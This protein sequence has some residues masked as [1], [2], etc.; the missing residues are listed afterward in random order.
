MKNSFLYTVIFSFILCFLSVLIL[1]FLNAATLDKVNQYREFIRQQAILQALGAKNILTPEDAQAQYGNVK[2][3]K[4]GD[5]TYYFADF[6]G[7]PAVVSNFTGPG[8]WG[9]ISGY[10]GFSQ[11]LT[12]VVGFEV[13]NQVET[14]GLGAR[15]SEPWFKEQLQGQNVVNDTIVVRKGGNGENNYDDGAIDGIS[16]ATRT[17]DGIQAILNKSIQQFHKD[18]DL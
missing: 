7:A 9:L 2:E 12:K 8:L 13:T 4:R 14:P 17:A 16:G 1:S 11:D 18:L 6:N 5:S 10:I 15:V 3:E